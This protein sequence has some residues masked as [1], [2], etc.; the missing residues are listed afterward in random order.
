MTGKDCPVDYKRVLDHVR[1]MSPYRD[2]EPLE[3]IQIK[4]A[5]EELL[6][7]EEYSCLSNEFK[8]ELKYV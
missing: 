5:A 8:D 4:K 2:E 1:A 7:T 6:K 3:P